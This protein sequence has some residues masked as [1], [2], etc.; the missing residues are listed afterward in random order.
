MAGTLF[1][2][3]RSL[4]KAQT[5]SEADHIRGVMRG[6]LDDDMILSSIKAN[7]LATPV[8]D[9]M[10]HALR[11]IHD[12]ITQ[13]NRDV[14]RCC[15]S[16]GSTGVKRKQPDEDSGYQVDNQDANHDPSDASVEIYFFFENFTNRTNRNAENT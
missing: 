12:T 4:D 8:F 11:H 6:L 13:A 2:H 7:N 10:N 3:Q 15:E 5:Y 1:D 9:S 16:V 14:G